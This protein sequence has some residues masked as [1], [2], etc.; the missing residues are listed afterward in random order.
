MRAKEDIAQYL[1]IPEPDLP[2]V[3]IPDEMLQRIVKELPESPEVKYR[4]YIGQGVEE[5]DANVIARDLAL[6]GLFEKVA[7]ATTPGYAS[8]W[9]RRD[10]TAL[11][12]EGRLALLNEYSDQVVA[13]FSL[14]YRKRISDPTTKEILKTLSQ[15]FIEV[16][17]YVKSNNLELVE[18]TSEFEHIIDNAISQSPDAVA[19]VKAGKEKALNS[20][21]GKVMQQ[22]KGKA[23]PDQ[24]RE[25]IVKKLKS[26]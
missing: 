12:E 14:S 20:I 10:M 4:K 26:S 2:I 17:Q 15:Q 11:A 6:A 7:A 25:I 1:F 9:F 22:T 3:E 16:E 13:L 24:V 8:K 23:R 5:T 21:V 18:D 19:D